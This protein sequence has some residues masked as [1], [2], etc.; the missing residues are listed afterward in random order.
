MAGFVEENY[1]GETQYEFQ[2]AICEKDFQYA[3]IVKN[4]HVY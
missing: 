4:K 1:K 2:A 3:T